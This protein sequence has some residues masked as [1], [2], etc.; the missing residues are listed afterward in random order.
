MNELTTAEAIQRIA[1]L[2]RLVS[3]RR[4]SDHRLN[5]VVSGLL[6]EMQLAVAKHDKAFENLSP[7]LATINAQLTE[8]RTACLGD[9]FGNKGFV[10]RLEESKAD[11][12]D[13]RK[14]VESH[15]RKLMTWGGAGAALLLAFELAKD[16]L[17]K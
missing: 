10:G 16:K 9:N 15:D 8:I 13:L 7:A 3:E 11:R 14:I 5:N 6:G 1:D 17:F 4:D 12:A 2:E